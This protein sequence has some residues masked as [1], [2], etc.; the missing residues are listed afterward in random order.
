MFIAVP[1][2]G[3]PLTESAVWYPLML[4]CPMSDPTA[5]SFTYI[6]IPDAYE[7]QDWTLTDSALIENIFKCH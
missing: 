6:Q 7:Q 2:S 5:L 3:I 1:H 4:L